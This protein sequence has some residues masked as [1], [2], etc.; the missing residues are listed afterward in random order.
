MSLKKNTILVFALKILIA[1]LGF[2]FNWLL[3]KMIG[4][5][6]IGDYQ[7]ILTFLMISA[8]IAEMG[9]NT[10]TLRLVSASLAT[11]QISNAKEYCLLA[12]EYILISTTTV[13]LLIFLFTNFFFS[14]FFPTKLNLV[15]I[16][17][18]TAL[19]IIPFVLGN[20][21]AEILKAF[22]NFQ[23]SIWMQN[24]FSPL[25]SSIGLVI[26]WYFDSVNVY[27]VVYIYIFSLWFN[28]FISIYFFYSHRPEKWNKINLESY[29]NNK[30][31]RKSAL[32]L[33]IVS[34]AASSIGY[35]DILFIGL[36]IGAKE[37][38]IYVVA[39]KVAALNV[40]L[41]TSVNT[42]V[43]SQFAGLFAQ[44][45]LDR[46][47]ELSQKATKNLFWS[48]LILLIF[49]IIC[50]KPI[51]GIF[52]ETFKE[53]YIVL[54]IMSFGQF[55]NVA[56]G[57]VGYL[58]TMT[59]HESL[60]KTNILISSAITILLFIVLIPLFS[61]TGAAIA[62]ASTLAFQNLRTAWLVKKRLGFYTLELIYGK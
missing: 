6:G 21:F 26:L 46:L 2:A 20:L 4:A 16:I 9:I 22:G 45:K 29:K 14:V 50:A 33:W 53:G 40:F 47:K 56:T 61:I 58:L 25:F 35:I 48:G 10:A 27:N 12:I 28:L 13:T 3:A 42:V 32:Q 19:G 34:L 51:L 36:W 23:L 18:F 24:G 43:A 30:I 1:F 17:L 55:I 59:G 38:G 7:I 39:K 11:N 15:Y 62:S 54:I 52:G 44:N 31:L 49:F 60:Y 5:K 57:S 8:L 37:A 41:L